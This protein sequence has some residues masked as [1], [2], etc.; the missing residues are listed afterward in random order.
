MGREEK[1]YHSGMRESILVKHLLCA[2]LYEKQKQYEFQA[3]IQL[4]KR[5]FK[6]SGS[7]DV[8][9]RAFSSSGHL[10]EFKILRH[11]PRTKELE[12]LEVGSQAL[13]V[14]QIY[15]KS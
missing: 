8:V 6:V 3:S 15:A 13:Q 11:H 14:I 12:T 1:P 10:L 2:Q 9:P 5:Q 7:T 4:K